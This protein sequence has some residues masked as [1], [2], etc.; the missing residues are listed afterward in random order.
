VSRPARA[1]LSFHPGLRKARLPVGAAALGL[2]LAAAPARAFTCGDAAGRIFWFAVAGSSPAANNCFGASGFRCYKPQGGTVTVELADPSCNLQLQA[3][4]VRLRV[5]FQFPGANQTFQEDGLAV[6]QVFWFSGATSPPCNGTSDCGQIAVCS[7]PGQAMIYDFADTYVTKSVTCATAVT[8]QEVYSLTAWSCATGCRQELKVEG[9]VLGG[10]GLAAAIGCPR[11]PPPPCTE[12]PGASTGASG[13]SCPLCQP[14]GGGA[15]GAGCSVGV[16]GGGPSCEPS[17]LG[18]AQVRY[19]AGG[20]GGENL[21]GAAAWRTTL[22]RF[23][24]HDFAERIV[25]DPDTSHVWLLTRYGSY[26]EFWNLAAGSGLRLYQSRGPSDEF[27]KLYLDTATG[28]WEL[29]TLDGRK[30][31]GTPALAT[32]AAGATLWQG[33]FDPFGRDWSGAEEA[34][35]FLRFPGQWV[36]QVWSSTELASGLHY[37]LHRWYE[38]RAGTYAQPDPLGVAGGLNLFGYVDANPVRFS[39]PLGLIR[40]VKLGNQKWRWCTPSEEAACR[41]TCKYGME[42]CRVSQTFRVTRVTS[43]L[44]VRGWVDGPISCSCKEPSCWER[45]RDWV[46]NLAPDPTPAPPLLRF[47]RSYRHRSVRL[48]RSR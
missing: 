25:V 34:G 43:G 45:M 39:D 29:H 22:G 19:A 1:P 30:D 13:M 11:P 35:V 6:G 3:C 31:V 14:V 46:N 18:K 8:S 21:P 44:V 28:G 38:S 9:L 26:R 10:P 16:A 33:G 40:P 23:W 47:R 27:R 20:V 32:G 4:T 5:S 17:G 2:L 48:C 12:P 37:N 36:D 7:V 41:A 15:G 24:S 42:S